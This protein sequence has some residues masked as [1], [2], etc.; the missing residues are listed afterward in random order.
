MWRSEVEATFQSA[1]IG[2]Y[3]SPDFS[4]PISN[5]QSLTWW[6]YREAEPL[7]RQFLLSYLDDNRAHELTFFTNVSEMWEQLMASEGRNTLNEVRRLV[8]EWESLKQDSTDTMQVYI[9]KIDLTAARLG[10]KGLFKTQDEKLYKLINGMASHWDTQRGAL[11]ITANIQSYKDVCALLLGI[12]VSRGEVAGDMATGGEAY[13]SMGPNGARNKPR[14]GKG[15]GSAGGKYKPRPSPSSR[16]VL[17]CM[18]CNSMEHHT[19]NCPIVP[20]LVKD[21]VSGRYP[22][23]CFSCH[24]PGHAS[25]ECP[26]K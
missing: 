17:F 10:E 8:A 2:N 7:A 4:P 22:L 9:R 19:A 5:L 25:R 20:N 1:K 6:Q 21:V 3:L 26:N 13:F 18:G 14:Y 23:I 12:A 24:K 16:P 15:G 11:E